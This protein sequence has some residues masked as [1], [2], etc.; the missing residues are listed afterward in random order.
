M[1]ESDCP[2]IVYVSRTKRTEELAIKLTRD[3][4]NALPFN[5]RMEPDEKIVNQDAF[6]NDQVRIIVA[7]SAFWHGSR[8]E[9][10]RSW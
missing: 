3:G 8:Q 2:T 4:Y 1:A 9:R 7:T 5:G 6:M 10:C